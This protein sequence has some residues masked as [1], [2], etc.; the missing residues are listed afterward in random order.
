MT[1][2]QSEGTAVAGSPEGHSPS[3]AT[4]VGSN[5]HVSGHQDACS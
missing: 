1:G 5:F 3:L 4:A 2:D